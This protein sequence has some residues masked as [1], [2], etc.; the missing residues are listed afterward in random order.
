MITGTN[1]PFYVFS[2]YAANFMN[3]TLILNEDL[4]AYI[5]SLQLERFDGFEFIRHHDHHYKIYMKEQVRTSAYAVDFYK[6]MRLFSIST[7]T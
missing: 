1:A 2:L 3:V 5:L 7:G 4:I 6:E